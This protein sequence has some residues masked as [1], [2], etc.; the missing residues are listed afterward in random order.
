[1]PAAKPA[2]EEVKETETKLRRTGNKG[3][4]RIAAL[5]SK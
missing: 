1:M 3:L 2:H 5:M 4:D